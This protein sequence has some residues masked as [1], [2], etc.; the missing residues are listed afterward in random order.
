MEPLV[1]EAAINGATSKRRNPHTPHSVEE[2]VG[3]ALACLAAGATV[4]HNH[5]GDAVLGGAGRHATEPYVEVYERV[6]A[7]RP[8]AVLYPTMAGGQG[9]R[10]IEERY[11]HIVDLHERGLLG[12]AVADPGSLNL[13]GV[14]KGVPVASDLVYQN[15]SADV[16]WMFDW[17]TRHEAPT[18]IS[19]FEPG[20]LQLVLAHRRVGTLPPFAKVQLYLAGPESLFGLP[21]DDWGLDTYLRMLEGSG[22]RWMVAVPGGDVAATG[23]ARRAIEAG[24]HVRVGLE[25][26]RGPEHPTNAELVA[27]VVEL[28]AACG[29]P[30]ATPAEAYEVLHTAWGG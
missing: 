28:A 7:E 18:H 19:I 25:D 4:V 8:D 5:S 26:H 14:R 17:C 22:L 2:Q 23:L 13:V 11:A 30:V 16:A 9:A 10:G 20:F 29:R 27:E 15:T 24:G 12:M 21:A 1:I 3:D 6:L